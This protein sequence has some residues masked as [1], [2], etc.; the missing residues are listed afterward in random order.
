MF[1][2]IVYLTA[3]ESK[4]SIPQRQWVP[5]RQSMKIFWM[6]NLGLDYQGRGLRRL[7][8]SSKF[9]WKAAGERLQKGV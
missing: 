4:H 6:A 8:K 7:G 9:S 2:K 5:T 1:Q 3:V